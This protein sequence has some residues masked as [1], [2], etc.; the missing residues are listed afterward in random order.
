MMEW[1]CPRHTPVHHTT[2]SNLGNGNDSV[3]KVHR[4][5]KSP[6]PQLSL[7]LDNYSKPLLFRKSVRASFLAGAVA[8]V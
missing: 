6:A 2:F 1:W 8:G 3:I 5:E 7:L 4:G